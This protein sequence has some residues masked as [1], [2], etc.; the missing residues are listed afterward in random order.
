ML[1][2]LLSSTNILGFTSLEF[3][4]RFAQF[5]TTSCAR[6]L[7][8]IIVTGGLLLFY[9]IYVVYTFDKAGLAFFRDRRSKTAITCYFLDCS[10]YIVQLL[11]IMAI[12]ICQPYGYLKLFNR[13]L[14]LENK[15]KVH[16]CFRSNIKLMFFKCKKKQLLVVICYFGCNCS[17]AVLRGTLFNTLETLEYV[18]PYSAMMVAFHMYSTLSS[19]TAGLIKERFGFV[20]Q[21]VMNCETRLQSEK[22]MNELLMISF[23][24]IDELYAITGMFSACF[25]VCHMT[26]TL[27][28][29]CETTLQAYFICEGLLQKEY[30]SQ[31]PMMFECN[32]LMDVL[33]VVYQWIVFIFIVTAAGNLKKEVCVC[34]F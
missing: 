33:W 17:M 6:K 29:F 21:V 9:G 1:T 26:F 12:N 7:F 3:D 31:H 13:I 16:L 8:H 19:T 28:V 18:V 27:S 22:Q 32:A 25:R 20:K 24:C 30:L 2:Y 34:E 23:Q 4:A 10:I 14:A 5:R 11:V 15:L